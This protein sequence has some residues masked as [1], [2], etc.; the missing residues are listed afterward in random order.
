[1]QK[2]KNY[3]KRSNKHRNIKHVTVKHVSVKNVTVKHNQERS[4]TKK[5]RQA[6]QDKQTLD[7]NA[8]DNFSKKKRCYID[9]EIVNICKSG[10]FT[11]INEEGLYN[12]ENM[13]IFNKM[14]DQ[15]NRYKKYKKLKIPQLE[16]TKFLM[17]TFEKHNNDKKEAELIKHD[18]YGY[19]NDS[20]L[21]KTELEIE[22]TPKFY[23][24]FDTFR[25]VQEKVYY[26][27]IGYVKDYIKKNPHLEKAIAIKNI[28]MSMSTDT[29]K[30]TRIQAQALHDVIGNFIEKDD[31]YALLA[32]INSNEIVSWGSPIVWKSLPDEKN[33]KKYISHLSPV[34]L[35]LYDYILYI[36]DPADN[37]E[38]K[39]Y[40][41]FIKSH[42]LSY[43]RETFKAC[44]GDEKYLNYDPEDIW[45][46]ELDLLDAM[47]CKT[48]YKEDPDGYNVLSNTELENNL[49]F[50][51]NYFSK[52]L[53]FETPP[54]KII[55][56]NVNAI[57][58][59]THLL[60]KNWNTPKWKTYW[61]FLYFRQMTRFEETFR[62]IHFDF[63]NKLLEG[64]PTI[65]PSEIYPIYALS[66]TFNTFLTEEY[67]RHNYNQLYVNY[68]NH[69]ADDLKTLFIRKLKRNTWLSPSTKITAIKKLEKLKFYVGK[70]ESLRYDPLHK[71]KDND[72]W[73]NMEVLSRWKHKKYVSL[74][75]KE[76]IDIP[77]IDWKNFKLV[78]TQAYMVNAYYMPTGN[79]IYIPLAYLQP[80]FIDLAEKGLEYNLT[81]IGYTIGHELSHALDDVGSKFDENGNLHNWW[82]ERD[83]KIFQSKIDN[84]IKQYEEFAARDGIEFDASFG[85]GEDLADI[86]GLSLIEEYLMDNQILL[87]YIDIVKR[88]RLEMFYTYIAI[89]G[90]Q[91]IYKNAL[92]AQLKINPHPLEKYRVNCPLSRLNIFRQIF[93]IKKGDGM[94]WS[95]TDTI[96]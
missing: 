32:Y 77:E 29:V 43:V 93:G 23:V 9:Q 90:K 54:K 73:F 64:Q 3:N 85:V 31:M 7:K 36:D 42:Y 84:V 46:V 59:I 72:P 75:N 47:G 61:L 76:V 30:E 94:W 40:K 12:P 19:V 50:D 27:L 22:D 4:K 48:V 58:C 67:V 89:Q 81:Y 18:F 57:K 78:G 53:G 45:Q 95:N 71:Y 91:K 24:Q 6:T 44:L 96:W 14:T 60:K 70:P 2:N 55:V 79:S 66:M 8:E 41:K 65:M 25:V 86:S 52:Q 51:W 34:Q 87:E 37:K 83:T 69:L 10:K 1:M 28:Y 5:N 13:K 80:P 35:S 38:A 39:T 88:N 17:D 56:S 63:Y 62:H 68:V 11:K 15:L 21:K 20:W 16:Y 26:E 74:E 92:K 49:K 33:V 82:T